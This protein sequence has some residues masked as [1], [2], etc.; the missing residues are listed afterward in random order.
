MLLLFIESAIILLYNFYDIA[1]EGWVVIMRAF[2]FDNTIYR[3]ESVQD[4]LSLAD[5]LD[6]V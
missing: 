3:G 6:D 1:N 5:R 2:D 4:L